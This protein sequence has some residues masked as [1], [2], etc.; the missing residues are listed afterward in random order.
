MSSH[1][2]KGITK[3]EC[4]YWRNEKL[5]AITRT[6]YVMQILHLQPD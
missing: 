1:E 4:K 6:C 3:A 5:L 2:L